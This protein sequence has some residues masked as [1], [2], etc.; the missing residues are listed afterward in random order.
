MRRPP[1]RWPTPDGFAASSALRVLPGSTSQPWT[2]RCFFGPDA[3]NAFDF[4]LGV[5]GWMLEGLDAEGRG[6]ALDALRASIDR[7]V[8]ERGVVYDSAAWIITAR[9]A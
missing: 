9:R 4:V 2:L 7:H 6:R 5:T 3:A 1:S 8:T